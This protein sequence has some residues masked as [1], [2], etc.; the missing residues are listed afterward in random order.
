MHCR[1][2]TAAGGESAVLQIYPAHNLALRLSHRLQLA[3]ICGLASSML[4]TTSCIAEPRG[5]P[6]YDVMH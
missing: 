3:I 6:A 1:R 5:E 4:G 2:H